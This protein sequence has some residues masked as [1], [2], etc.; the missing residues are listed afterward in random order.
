MIR[1]E[2]QIAA[3]AAMEAAIQGCKEAYGQGSERAMPGEYVTVYE[4][5]EMDADGNVHYSYGVLLRGTS[6]TSRIVGLLE[7]ASFDLKLGPRS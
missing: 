3:D 6:A 5:S 1:N 7:V 2:S 4:E